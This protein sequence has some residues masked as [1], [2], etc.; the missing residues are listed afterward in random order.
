MDGKK[1]EKERGG[2]GEERMIRSLGGMWLVVGGKKEGKRYT[3][4]WGRW[5]W[6]EVDEEYVHA[7]DCSCTMDCTC[8]YSTKPL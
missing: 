7:H 5:E 4:I 8:V 3:C 2:G 1:G 6:K